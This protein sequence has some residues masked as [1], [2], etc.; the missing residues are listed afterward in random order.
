MCV[1]S[2][3]IGMLLAHMLK[4][5]CG[6]KTVV[7]GQG[8]CSNSSFNNDYKCSEAATKENSL[9]PSLILYIGEKIA[10]KIFADMTSAVECQNVVIMK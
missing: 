1:V 10:K 8:Q 4:D 2:F 9:N 6:C 3:L 5:V 7:E